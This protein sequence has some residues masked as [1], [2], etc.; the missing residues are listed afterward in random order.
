MKVLYVSKALVVGAYRDKLRALETHCRVTAVIPSAWNG[1]AVDPVHDD[2]HVELADTVLH[3]HN[4]FHLYRHAG[5]FIDRARPDIVHIDEEPYSAVTAQVARH[6]RKRSIP[7]CFFAW[8]NIHKRIPPPFAALRGYVFRTARGGIAGTATAADVLR[9]WGWKGPIA[10]IPQFGVDPDRFRP[11]PASRRTVRE[12][13]G[14][15]QSFVVGFGGRLVPERG[16]HLLASTLRGGD[17]THLLF[18]G[19]GPERQKLIADARALGVTDRVHLAGHVP[20]HDMPQWL[21]AMDVLVLP[22]LRSR[23]WVE[24][25]GR[26]LVEAMAC[27][28]PVIGSDSGEIPA[29]IGDAGALFPEGDGAALF[30][31]IRALRASENVRNER[32]MRGQARVRERF[33]Q[34]RVAEQTYAFYSSM[35]E[36]A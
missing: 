26:I 16:V 35:L 13:L 12:R 27:G 5:D 7:C 20:S 23:G 4:H 24:Q 28:V 22:S 11:D 8:Q 30:D 36:A 15:E 6:C 1:T 19:D 9:A 33:T 10:I 3:G 32:S 34:A 29:V 31:A 18:A 14:L 17:D 21:N 25:F 2:E